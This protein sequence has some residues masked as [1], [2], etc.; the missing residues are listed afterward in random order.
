MGSYKLL[1][2]FPS[3]IVLVLV[4]AI[5]ISV[6][7]EQQF[8][9]LAYAFL[10][11]HLNF[12][13]YYADSSSD[14]VYRN[15]RYYWALGP[16]PAVI[17]MPFVFI[18]QYADDF[19]YQGYLQCVLIL[20]LFGLLVRFGKKLHYSLEDSL[21]LAFGFVLGSAFIG[22]AAVSW[23]WYFAQVVAVSLSFWALFEY[24]GRKRWWLIGVVCALLL[25]QAHNAPAVRPWDA[26]PPQRQLALE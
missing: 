24:F 7:S 19:F 1:K 2:F 20:C 4:L 8:S 17:L 10:H 11:G 23:S 21:T 13:K 14:V 15:G 18:A 22:I 12:L 5:C 26:C 16:L 3:C 9:H 25:L 6:N